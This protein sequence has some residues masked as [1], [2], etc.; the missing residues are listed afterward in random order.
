MNLSSDFQ[1]GLKLI[2]QK[3]KKSITA[4]I[5]NSTH[6][7][8]YIYG[9]NHFALSVIKTAFDYF[10]SIVCLVLLL[11]VILSLALAIKTS[12]RGPVFYSQKRIGRNGKSFTIYKFRS[13]YPGSEEGTTLISCKNDERISKIGRFMR[14]HKFDE[15]PNFINVIRGEMSIV[16][17]RPEQQYFVDKIVQQAPEYKLL[18]N[19]KP[20]ITSWGQVKYGYA[21]TVEK[22]IERLEY[23]IHYL[24]NR[25]LWFDTKIILHTIAIIFKGEGI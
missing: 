19:I 21:S 10:I 24:K 18:Q 9:M 25:S 2:P 15:I 22:M 11:P 3:Y 5:R 13:M 1:E 14:K 17:P 4:I 12:D 6:F 16:G 23:D 7:F 20:G 8:L